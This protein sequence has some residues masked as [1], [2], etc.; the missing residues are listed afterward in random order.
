MLCAVRWAKLYSGSSGAC[1]YADGDYRSTARYGTL[2]AIASSSDGMTLYISDAGNNRIRKLT[3]WNGIVS[4]I[5]GN[6]EFSSAAPL[7]QLRQDHHR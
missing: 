1:A 4:T 6:G 7:R 2:S 5:A 3:R